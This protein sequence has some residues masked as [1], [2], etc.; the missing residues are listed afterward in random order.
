MQ[1]I[2]ALNDLDYQKIEALAFEIIPEY[3]LDY[4]SLEHSL[5]FLNKYQK[6]P[7]I[8]QQI[9]DGYSLYYLLKTN[10]RTIGYLG[11]DFHRKHTMTLSK[12]Y[13]LKEHRGHGF[14]TKALHF[15]MQQAKKRNVKVIDLITN[16]KNKT[17]IRF[18]KKHGFEITE[19]LTQEHEDGYATQDYKMIKSL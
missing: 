15:V 11:I 12:V 3:Y 19:E 9:I 1:I 18:Y 6:A 16:Q 10:F 7:I 4:I 14:G 13:L 2:K 8:K 17:A 5:F